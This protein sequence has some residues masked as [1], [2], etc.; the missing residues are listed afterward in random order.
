MRVDVTP[1][2][3]RIEPG[4]ASTLNVSIFNDASIIVAYRIRVL[5]LDPAWVTVSDPRP[6]L[7]PD[8]ASDTVVVITLPVDAPAGV[9]RIGV[10]VTSL[11]EPAI[12]E[13]VEVEID[14]PAEPEAFIELEPVSVFGTRSGN[15]GV[16]TTN[17]GNTPLHIEF[18]ADD[19]DDHLTFRFDP[20]TISLAPGERGF[21][22]AIARGRRPFLGAAV[23]HTFNVR[24]VDHPT[25]R[26]AIGSLV[27]KA[28]I[29]RGALSLVGLLAAISIFAVVL[30]TS[31]GRVVDR[32]RAS[33]AALLEVIR[34]ESAEATVTNPGTL[35]G[36]VT[37][38]TSGTPVSGVTVD[39]FR[40]DDSSRPTASTA[41]SD[42]GEFGFG[43]LAEASYRI[44]VRG[45]G[46][47]EVWFPSGLSFDEA[48][49]VNVG[50]GETVTGL[51]VRLGGVPG[52]IEGMIIGEDPGG[53]TISLEVPADV[54]A[55][56]VDAIVMSTVV[57]AT[58]QFRLE[59]VPAPSSY[60]LRVTKPGFA[61]AVRLV[62]IAAGEDIGGVELALRSG[63][64][65]ISGMVLDGSGPVGGATIV[66][67]A[68]QVEARSASLTQAN[69]G[70]FTLRDLP[71]PGTYTLQVGAPGYATETFSLRLDTA[72][73]VTDVQV[74]LRNS[75]GSV[76]GMASI[77]GEGP[78]G[79][80]TVTVS[81]GSEQWSTETLSVGNVGSYVVADLPLPGNYTITFS[82]AGL[83]TQIR[84]VDLDAFGGGNRSDINANLTRADAVIGG[85]ITDQ[86]SNPLGG[87]QVTAT[88]GDL[89]LVTVSAHEPAGRYELR[90]L[91]AGT[92][93][94][95]FERPGSQPTAVLVALG[96]AEVRTL[97]VTLEPQASVRG[98]VTV[99]GVPTGGLQVR[100]FLIEQYPSTILATTISQA[101]GTYSFEALDAPQ[102]YVVEFL[103]AG[104]AVV[105]TQTVT[106]LAGEQRTGLDFDLP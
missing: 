93:T 88:R 54:I 31:L 47:T 25:V 75:N 46:F 78:V 60:V 37:L 5:G 32:T 101:D 51:E 28:W 96:P 81:D 17:I 19:P 100:L 71:T 11:T 3:V 58:G 70:S 40:A 77:V 84:S 20:P 92:Y 74:Q 18:E 89:A 65:S 38:L 79:G 99:G 69:V 39:L 50:E 59:S 6:S 36:T 29:S 105:G 44:R 24:A 82:R 56:E 68:G 9:R 102:T 34:G 53:A 15:F 86:G 95:T 8:T 45:A 22:Q 48:D 49:D 73:Q 57:D 1:Q 97:D 21:V 103:N 80:V 26:P 62:N 67:T 64:G 83:A 87:V 55:G 98:R 52:S 72:Q 10:E 42:L 43:A 41:T 12:T 2:A 91:P 30:T 7:F 35:N 94:L 33:E 104:G 4:R 106:L 66:A 61:S 63:D 90:D 14:I 16:A 23:A 76:A 13:I 85:R 27:Q